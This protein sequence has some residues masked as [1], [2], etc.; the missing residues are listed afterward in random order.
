MK[1]IVRLTESDLIRIVKQVIKEGSP[2]PCKYF[3]T[4]LKMGTPITFD[5][6]EICYDEKGVQTSKKDYTGG[7]FDCKTKIPTYPKD[8]NKGGSNEAFQKE[9]FKTQPNT[10]CQGR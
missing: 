6:Q 4:N 10:W 2:N 8:V 1:K 3:L 9:Y 5:I 7:S